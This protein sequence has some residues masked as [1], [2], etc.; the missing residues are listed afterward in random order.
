MNT[1]VRCR[2]SRSHTHACKRYSTP[3]NDGAPGAYPAAATAESDYAASLY[4]AQV[5]NR[6][7]HGLGQ[8]LSRNRRR[9]RKVIGLV[10]D[11]E[12]RCPG[13]RST[14]SSTPPGSH[15]AVVFNRP[16]KPI[17]VEGDNGSSR[18]GV[19]RQAAH[20]RR[21][22]TRPGTGR[23]RSPPASGI[24]V[25]SDDH[26]DLPQCQCGGGGV[27]A[28]CR[29]SG[30]ANARASSGASCAWSTSTI[31]FLARAGAPGGFAVR[32]PDQGGGW[33]RGLRAAP[34]SRVT[35]P[36]AARPA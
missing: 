29:A 26:T 9:C 25:N 23:F 10:H 27:P 21:P 33:V 28:A 16:N 7:Q 24:S 20:P 34:A 17:G 5:G 30:L 12:Y 31:F 13:S 6:M 19:R 11:H 36:T 3:P 15:A 2:S 14:T 22:A 18:Y 8:P 35:P 4:S 1:P 32:R